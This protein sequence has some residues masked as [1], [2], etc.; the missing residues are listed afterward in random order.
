LTLVFLKVIFNIRMI[1]CLC[2]GVSDR[3]V[4]LLV[5]EGV[6]TPQA[7]ERACGAGGDCGSCQRQVR[8]IIDEETGQA[9]CW[10]LPVLQTG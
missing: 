4:R 5:E 3:T 1:V 9:P 7:I 10:T 2:R 6:D 8:Q